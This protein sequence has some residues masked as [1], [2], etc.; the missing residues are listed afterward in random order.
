MVCHNFEKNMGWVLIAILTLI[1]DW[2]ENEN[3]SKHRVS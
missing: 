3:V 1:L 2:T